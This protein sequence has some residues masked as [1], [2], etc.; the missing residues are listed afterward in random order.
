MT[1][2]VATAVRYWETMRRLKPEQI[3][4]RVWFRVARPAIDLAPAPEVR[5]TQGWVAPA[6][7]PGSF[8]DADTFRFLNVPGTLSEIGWHGPEREK[9]WRYNQHY[10]DDLGAESSAERDAARELLILNWL[11]NNPPGRGV[12][13]EPYPLSL[14]IVNWI[15][16]GLARG[17]LT[18]AIRHSLAVQ[19]RYLTGR[20]ERHLLGNHLFANA[21]AL[22]FAGRF[23]DGAEADRWAQRGFAI[24]EREFDEQTLADGA[25]FELSPMY[26]ALA[27]EDVLD[28]LNLTAASSGPLPPRQRQQTEHWRRA[29]PKMLA[30]LE[31]MTHPDGDIS[32]FNDAAFG[33]APPLAT[34]Q[35]YAQRLGIAPPPSAGPLTWLAPSG[36]ARL[37]VGDAVL[38]CDLAKVGPDYLPGHA[39]ADTLSCELSVFGQRIIVNGGTSVYGVSEERLRQRGTAAHS[40]VTV[41]NANSSD[42]WSGFRVGRRA[43][44]TNVQ[45]FAADS[46]LLATGTHDGYRY[47]PG[48]PLHT[49]RWQLAPGQ[50]RIEDQ[51]TT[52]DLPAQAR[53]HLHPDVS[54]TRT[55]PETADLRLP[56][57][58]R[59]T[60]QAA[61]LDLA[62]S[63]WH[64]AFGVTHNTRVLIAPLQ[65][66]Q[67]CLT[68]TW[69][70]G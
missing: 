51:I 3:Y 68:L 43:R 47:L 66:G 24:L 50:L 61:G 65:A 62:P 59:L 56:G 36:Y 63:T 38:L 16:W 57:G 64:P 35:A 42:V 7:R 55:G 46:A 20:L 40:T 12:G 11:A 19:A 37:A 21:K 49:R 69:T 44:V 53:F 48:K 29:V 18:P 39:H 15:K 45:V 34:L 41:A 27:T 26:H 9:L 10:F 22:I 67:A 14:R 17:A 28:L 60:A 52:P 4:G 5:N 2:A 6:S 33:V 30:W 54:A 1:N 8:S 58:Q 25:Q 70:P 31:A 32:F 13:W 23:F